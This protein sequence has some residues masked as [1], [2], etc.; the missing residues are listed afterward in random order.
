[1]LLSY[2]RQ[3]MNPP[4]PEE[5]RQ[6][7]RNPRI[8]PRTGKGL[9]KAGKFYRLLAENCRTMTE[10]DGSIATAAI[11]IPVT[12]APGTRTPEYFTKK[13]L[14]LMAKNFIP[15]YTRLNIGELRETLERKLTGMNTTLKERYREI[16][17]L[18]PPP[19]PP[20]RIISPVSSLVSATANRKKGQNDGRMPR[21]S[22]EGG[23]R[24]KLIIARNGSPAGGLHIKVKTP[25]TSRR[26]VVQ[27]KDLGKVLDRMLENQVDIPG[28]MDEVMRDNKVILFTI[29]NRGVRYH[30]PTTMDEVDY[31]KMKYRNLPAFIRENEIPLLEK[32]KLLLEGGCVMYHR[33]TEEQMSAVDGYDIL[34]MNYVRGMGGDQPLKSVLMTIHKDISKNVRTVD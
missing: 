33:L 13:Q 28:L 16:M 34:D 23:G 25:Q 10:G 1:M 9:Y 22:L 30:I 15:G 32:G 6:F 11:P 19:S 29:T 4:S 7:R 18:A 14:N 24:L 27:T 5:C 2:P 12:I 20:N 8:N 3:K 17:G 26:G 21:R 31:E